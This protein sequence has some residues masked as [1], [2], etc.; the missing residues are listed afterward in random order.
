MSRA[1][2]VAHAEAQF[3][4]GS[5]F[6][7]LAQ[8]VACRTESQNAARAP[9]LRAYLDAQIAPALAALGFT[10]TVH[11]NPVAGAPPLLTAQRLED[12]A[13]PTVLFYGHG[14]VVR[15]HEGQRAEGRDPWTLT[16]ARTDSGAHPSALLLMVTNTFCPA[17]AMPLMVRTSNSRVSS[18]TSWMRS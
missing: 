7:T 3:D 10:S 8:R 2:A 17:P 13:L 9:E 5:F 14:D 15:G 16:D 18:S 4:A 1:T 6:R 11:D 12:P